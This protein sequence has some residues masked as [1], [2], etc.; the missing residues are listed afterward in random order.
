[1]KRSIVFLVFLIS[2]AFCQAQ[3]SS[4]NR[5]AFV[6]SPQLSWLNSDHSNISSDG[7]L[8]GYNFGLV[9]DRFFDKNYALSTG[10]TINTT[11]GKLHYKE[12]TTMEIGGVE[13]EMD[14]ATYRLKYIEVPFGLKLLTNDFRRARYYGQFGLF[15]Q[16]N[17]KTNDG[18]G[19]SM[20]EE[21]RFFDMGYHLGGGMEYSLG[22]DTYLMIGL[23]YNNG[24]LD[25]T[26]NELSD[27]AVLHRLV[28]QFGIIF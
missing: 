24:F 27:K 1:M 13:K 4:R 12:G 7:N 6:L 28:F 17:I 3:E 2:V 22:G 21:V 25:V 14:N 20:S 23:L 10:L 26:S 19:K 18:H 16:F 5:L 11:G 9:W 15:G 8:S